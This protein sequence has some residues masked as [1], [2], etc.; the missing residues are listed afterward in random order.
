MITAAPR[1]QLQLQAGLSP[2]LNLSKYQDES[3]SGMSGSLFIVSMSNWALPFR[4]KGAA[5]SPNAVERHQDKL[6]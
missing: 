6:S 2:G 4:T 3:H 5:L 1:A